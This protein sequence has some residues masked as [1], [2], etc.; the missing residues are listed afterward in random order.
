MRPARRRRASPRRRRVP[1]PGRGAVAGSPVP[2]AL[3][4]HGARAVRAD[5]PDRASVLAAGA[6]AR[7][8]KRRLRHGPRDVLAIAG[9]TLLG[10]L[11]PV[12]PTGGSWRAAAMPR[13][14]R[15]RSC[16]SPRGARACRCCSLAWCCSGS[17]FGNATSLPPL[18]AQVEFVKEDVQRVVALIVGIAQ[19]DLRVRARRL[20][21]G[22][23]AG[24]SWRACGR[25]ALP[26]VAAASCRPPQSARF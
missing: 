22:P 21:S 26:F 5:R 24:A 20:R 13:S 3:R 10:W 9:R 18:I 2:D 14:S 23:G 15:D 4:R 25:G 12:V 6:G 11:M 7:R 17:A 8:A 16:C 19:G 1:L